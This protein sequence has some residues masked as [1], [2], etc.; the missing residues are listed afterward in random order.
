MRQIP[1]PPGERPP[2]VD[3]LARSL[4]GVGA[5]A[6]RCSSTW[7]ARRSPTAPSTTPP[8]RAEALR[9]TLLTPVVNATGVLLHTNLGRAP[10]AHHQDARAQS[11]RARPGDRRARLAPAR[12]RQPA[13]PA[14]RRRGGDRR[15]QQRRRRAA[16]ARRARRRAR[17]AGQPRRER[18]D[19]RRL[20]RARGDGAVRRPPRR[21]R[22]DE[23]HAARRLPPR[24]RSPGADVA[25]VLKVHPSNYRVDGFV[26]ATSV[27]ELATL[28]VPVVADLGSGLRRRHVPVVAGRR[29]RRRGWPASRP[30][31]RRSPPAPRS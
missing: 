16:R 5:A 29:T 9:R 31:A 3:A 28:G 30:P 4:A 24:R 13:R 17:R 18:R 15:Q 7:P 12:R 1:H 26:E 10:L 23:P 22:H 14:V 8:A 25:L 21:R 19:R 2:S 27:A 6:R 11:R 20:P